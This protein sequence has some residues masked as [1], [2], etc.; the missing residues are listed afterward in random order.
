M[1]RVYKEDQGNY[2]LTSVLGKVMEQITLS[3]ITRHVWDNWRIRLSQYRFIK[4]M[5]TNLISF[6]D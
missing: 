4:G 3:E 2:S 5:L 6:Y 1:T